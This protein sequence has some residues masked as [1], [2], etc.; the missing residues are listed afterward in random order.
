[1]YRKI[2]Y[3]IVG[4]CCF[5]SAQANSTI[6][7]LKKE[8]KAHP[9][10]G[11]AR[12]ELLARIQVLY[13]NASQVQD[14]IATSDSWLKEAIGLGDTEVIADAYISRVGMFTLARRYKDGQATA[15]RE[16]MAELL[17]LLPE[18]QDTMLTARAYSAL[19]GASWNFEEYETAIGQLNK[20]VELLEG[21]RTLEEI[22][23]ALNS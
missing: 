13:M 3:C 10:P 1:M 5:Y 12:F 6:D 7:S 22:C 23:N 14:A 17:A 8:L 9:E 15:L 21:R 18:V 16:S 19:G 11:E 20:A 2:L 4:L